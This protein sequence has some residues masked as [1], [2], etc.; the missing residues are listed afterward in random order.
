V[1]KVVAN[2]IAVPFTT[3]APADVAFAV[4]TTLEP[5][6]GAALDAVSVIEISLVGGVVPPPPPVLGAVG[7]SVWQPNSASRKT[8]ASVATVRVF[9]VFIVV[10][11]NILSPIAPTDSGEPD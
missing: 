8:V 6:I 3:L 4:I 5:A 7:D 1:P 10:S 9:I 2:S 11:P